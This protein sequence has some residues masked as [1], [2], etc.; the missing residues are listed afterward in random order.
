MFDNDSNTNATAINL[1]L[2]KIIRFVD[3]VKGQVLFYQNQYSLTKL[4]VAAMLDC[5][6]VATFRGGY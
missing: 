6:S 4:T 2:K 1:V 5:W 3:L